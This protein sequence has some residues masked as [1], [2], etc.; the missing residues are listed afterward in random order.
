MLEGEE[1]E[2]EE[3]ERGRGRGIPMAR[4]EWLDDAQVMV[5]RRD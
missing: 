5:D 2:E 4:D 1:E 3:E